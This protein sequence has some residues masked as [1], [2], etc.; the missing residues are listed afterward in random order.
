MLIIMSN[1]NQH[2]NRYPTMNNNKILN[3]VGIFV[4]VVFIFDEI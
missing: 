2:Q 4:G 1:T 3:N